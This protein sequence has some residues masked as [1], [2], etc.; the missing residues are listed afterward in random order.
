[1]HEKRFDYVKKEKA[2]SCPWQGEMAHDTSEMMR[3]VSM[4]KIFTMQEEK[5]ELTLEHLLLSTQSIVF[6]AK[7]DFVQR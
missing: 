2:H 3:C 5:G 6:Y 4:M 7:D 1:M